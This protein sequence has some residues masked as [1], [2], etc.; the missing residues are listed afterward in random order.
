[1]K[2]LMFAGALL[3]FAQDPPAKPAPPP[4]QDEKRDPT[5]ADAKL[6]EALLR[7]RATAPAPNVLLRALVILKGKA[8][9]ALLEIDGRLHR[10]ESGQSVGTFRVTS[11]TTEGVKLEATPS[12]QVV[13]LR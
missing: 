9:S 1:M 5:E 2:S 7:S 11:L 3:L 13:V 4:A 8:G 10:V 12:G 6:R